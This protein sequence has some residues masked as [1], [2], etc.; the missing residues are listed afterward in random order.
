MA[1]E[2]PDSGSNEQRLQEILH[3]YLQAIDAGKASDQEEIVRQHPDLADELRAFFADQKKLD[4]LAKSMRG[5]PLTE[6]LPS[7]EMAVPA[8]GTK[9]RYFGDYEVLE[10]IA[11]G[12]MGIVYKA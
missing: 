11:R 9:V 3:S 10:E 1:T 7:R 8:F 4:L 2:Q 5:G 6:G 12:G